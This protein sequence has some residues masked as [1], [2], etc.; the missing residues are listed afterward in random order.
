ML[1]S[2]AWV[3]GY[4][5]FIRTDIIRTQ[6]CHKSL[7]YVQTIQGNTKFI[8]TTC[9]FG[10]DEDAFWSFSIGSNEFLPTSLLIMCISVD[11]TGGGGGLSRLLLFLSIGGGGIGGATNCPGYLK[12]YCS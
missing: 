4:C 7:I 12:S 1:S 9:P 2:D 3:P 11:L 8:E 5:N 10:I 6:K